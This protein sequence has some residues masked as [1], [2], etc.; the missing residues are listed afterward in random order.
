M[1]D[2]DGNDNYNSG[3]GGNNNSYNNNNGSNGYNNSDYNN[4]YNSNN[5]NN[6][7]YN[8]NYGS[9]NYNNSGYNNNYSSNNYNNSG[10]NNNYGSNNSYGSSSYSS[11]PAR[12]GNA[13]SSR[14]ML[15]ILAVAAVLFLAASFG[16]NIVKLK[17]CRSMTTGTDTRQRLYMKWTMSSLP[18]MYRKHHINSVRD[19]LK[20]STTMSPILQK[21]IPTAIW[22]RRRQALLV[23]L[24]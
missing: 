18:L 5:Y 12:S 21:A 11:T 9:N 19:R 1:F 6:S 2:L 3:N 7:G 8:S 23:P 20:L 24:A 16:T 22:I 4:N 13:G 10:Y 17:N 14:F 15:L